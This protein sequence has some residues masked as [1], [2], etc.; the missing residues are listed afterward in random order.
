VGLSFPEYQN[1]DMPTYID[2]KNNML[3]YID[4]KNNIPAYF[5]FKY[6]MLT[7]ID[8]KNNMLTYIDFKNNMPTYITSLI[9]KVPACK[10]SLA[11]P[12]LF[13]IFLFCANVPHVPLF[14]VLSGIV[15]HTPSSC[16]IL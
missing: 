16:I 12:L 8:L 2:F 5:D 9:G 15:E 7:C 10:T 11:P 6:N 13:P 4:L 3:T 14:I 1:A